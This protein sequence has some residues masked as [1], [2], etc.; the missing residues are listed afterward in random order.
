MTP[1]P[2]PLDNAV[3][4][5]LTTRHEAFA[6]V[7]GTARRYPPDVSVFGAVG[8]PDLG[9]MAR[10]G[11]AGRAGW[12]RGAVPGRAPGATA[13]WTRLGG[14]RGHQMVLGELAAV[15]IPAAR[16]LG[17]ADVGEMLAL[18]ELTRGR[19]RSRSGRSSSAATSALFDGGE[20]VAMAGERLRLP[21]FCEI[22][23]VCTRPDHRGSRAGRRPD[24]ARRA[25]ASS[26]RGEQPFLHHAADNDPRS[27]GL[28]GA[29]LRVPPG[30]RRSRR[31]AR[32]DSSRRS[33]R[34][35]EQEHAGDRDRGTDG[36]PHRRRRGATRCRRGLPRRGESAVTARKPTT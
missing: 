30:G 27:P 2:S 36:N 26:A 12:A 13:G 7:A 10:P 25:R 33:A 15:D 3:W 28:R 21:G 4:H 35:A 20:L 8:E 19:D 24:R 22:S 6:E 32:P 23:A 17:P 16:A 18:V 14:G 5:A 9:D 29:R 31:T 34:S 1:E 11:G